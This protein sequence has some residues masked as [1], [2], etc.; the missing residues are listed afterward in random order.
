VTELAQ[1]AVLSAALDEGGRTYRLTIVRTFF[2]GEGSALLERLNGRALDFVE[3]GDWSI[4]HP[5]D[6]PAAL[7][8]DL[9]DSGD[10]EDLPRVMNLLIEQLVR[11]GFAWGIEGGERWT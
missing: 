7:R 4:S 2:V 8:V 9:D 10:V 3:N 6:G 5:D 1:P 11:D